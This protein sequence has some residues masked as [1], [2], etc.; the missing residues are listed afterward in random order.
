MK[1]RK[2]Q[3]HDLEALLA[4]ESEFPKSYQASLD[5]YAQTDCGAFVI[6]S[7]V[8]GALWFRISG[9]RLEIVSLAVSK[10]AQGKGLARKLLNHAHTWAR[11][12]GISRC[13]LDVTARNVRARAV[14]QAARYRV[15][16][17]SAGQL[18][19]QVEL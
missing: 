2:A 12:R 14:Y 6:G 10:P 5:F 13:F 8:Q 9:G 17:K 19:M 7:P 16:S 4:L 3:F 11:A 18:R 15:L 1:P